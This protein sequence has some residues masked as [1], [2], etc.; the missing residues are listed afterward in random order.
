MKN[1]ESDRDSVILFTK[2]VLDRIR[3]YLGLDF[4]KYPPLPKEKTF[5]EKEWERRSKIGQSCD[6]K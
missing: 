3:E 4:S 2:G 5:I 1:E 6:E